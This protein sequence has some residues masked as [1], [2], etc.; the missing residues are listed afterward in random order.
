[1]RVERVNFVCELRERREEEGAESF[2]RN[3]LISIGVR[4]LIDEVCDWANGVERQS[5]SEIVLDELRPG[6]ATQVL[7]VR[8]EAID[9]RAVSGE[10]I[11]L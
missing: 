5:T 9:K 4:R 3:Q 1:M 8:Q 11:C 7:I 6:L 2:G 10:V